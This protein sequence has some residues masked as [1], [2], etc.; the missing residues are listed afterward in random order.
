MGQQAVAVRIPQSIN[1]A[2]GFHVSCNFMFPHFAVPSEI[3]TSLLMYPLWLPAQFLS[4]NRS[5]AIL[6]L[7]HIQTNGQ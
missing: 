6:Q 4:G 3:S 2:L 7:D 1:E 5:F